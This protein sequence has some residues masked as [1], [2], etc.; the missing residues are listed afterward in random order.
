MTLHALADVTNVA[1]VGVRRAS[2]TQVV[3][4][5]GLATVFLGMFYKGVSVQWPESYFGAS[6]TA[7]YS[8][9]ISPVRYLSFRFLPVFAA[10]LFASVSINR[11]HGRSLLVVLSIAAI[12]SASTVGVSIVKDFRAPKAIRRHRAPV[13]LLRIITLLV[14]FAVAVI[15]NFLKVRAAPLIPTPQELSGTLW[16][17]AI[18][19]VAGAYAI[20][21]SR[22]RTSN[23]ME[24]VQ[25]S[26]QTI[27]V[28][29]RHF[30]RSVA[31]EH[32]ADPDLVIAVMIAENLQRPRWFRRLEWVK[33]FLIKNGTYGIMQVKSDHYIDDEDSI[34]IAVVERLANIRV[35]DAQ[36]IPVYAALQQVATAWN[37]D[38]TYDQ[39]LINAYFSVRPS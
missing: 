37:P 6:D 32:G 13:T 35:T 21:V 20:S 14:V 22:G 23:P 11:L 18:A 12:H 27:P 16:T 26:L 33:S 29:L 31:N 36:G 39:L 17:G 25:R 7:A 9:S 2:V 10:C 8:V 15:A 4:A 34:R 28:H 3:L 38:P 30:A 5:V 1:V 24:L 19:A